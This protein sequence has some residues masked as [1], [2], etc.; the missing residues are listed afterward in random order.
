M[1]LA[2]CLYICWVLP[3]QILLEVAHVNMIVF[4]ESLDGDCLNVS[5]TFP[6]ITFLFADLIAGRCCIY[7]WF[8]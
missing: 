5:L 7:D 8:P 4:L 2:Y 6:C 3:L 1:K